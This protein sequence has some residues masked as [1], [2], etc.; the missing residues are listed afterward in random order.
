MNHVCKINIENF[1][2]YDLVV[3][4]TNGRK[5]ENDEGIHFECLPPKIFCILYNC[6]FFLL[7]EKV[8]EA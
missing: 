4:F 6:T 2:N 8:C 3:V 7:K 1:Y 5:I